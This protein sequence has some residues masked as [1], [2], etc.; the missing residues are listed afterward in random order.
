MDSNPGLADACSDHSYELVKGDKFI[1]LPQTT[2]LGYDEFF[3]FEHKP[4]EILVVV[5]ECS[6]S[7]QR[8][9]NKLQEGLMEDE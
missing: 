2:K 8:I 4:G 6:R 9:L 3:T 7:I 5:F 1:R